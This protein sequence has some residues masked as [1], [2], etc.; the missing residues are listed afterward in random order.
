MDHPSRRELDEEEGL[1]AVEKRDR[2][3]E[4]ASQAQIWSACVREIG[5][6]LLASWRLCAN[7][8][9][10]LLNGAFAD[11]KAQFQQFT[12]DPFSTE[13]GDCPWPSL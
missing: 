8:S 3:P 5:R 6:P 12:P 2:S 4:S 11:T 1:R 7:S 10:I 13:D 9:Q